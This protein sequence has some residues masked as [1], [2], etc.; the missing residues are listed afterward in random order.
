[1]PEGE[2]PVE[3][4]S[5][6]HKLDIPTTW[7]IILEEKDG[8][9]KFDVLYSEREDGKELEST[10]EI[11]K[12]DKL[13]PTVQFAQLDKLEGADGKELEKSGEIHHFSKR[14][15]PRTS[16]LSQPAEK[17]TYIQRIN[18]ARR[19]MNEKQK[20]ELIKGLSKNMWIN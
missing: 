10:S 1:M 12:Y 15:D 13:D 4:I 3:E 20:A 5:D 19:H 17:K 18:L 14:E 8:K 2:K 11:P 6:G 16:K 7:A 9:E